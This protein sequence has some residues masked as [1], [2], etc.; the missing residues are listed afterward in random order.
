MTRYDGGHDED[1]WTVPAEWWGLAEPFRGLNDQPPPR[2]NRNALAELRMTVTRYRSTIDEVLAG[3]RREGLGNIAEAAERSV[4]L[5]AQASPLGA[6][7]IS[8][9]V[10]QEC[11]RTGSGTDAFRTVIADQFVDSWIQARGLAFAAETAVL[12][13]GLR[14]ERREFN[15]PGN[16]F[17]WCSALATVEPDGMGWFSDFFGDDFDFVGWR[18]RTHLAAAPETQYRAAAERLSAARVDPGTVWAR[19][20]TSY[21]LPERQDWLDEDLA[22]D[23]LVPRSG[24]VRMLVSAATTA[25]QFSRFGDISGTPWSYDRVRMY[26]ILTQIEPKLSVPTIVRKLEN[27][28]RSYRDNDARLFTALLA[29]I[30]SDDAYRA[31]LDHAH[32]GYGA[33]AL[34]KAS[35]RFPCR[36]ARL[37]PERMAETPAPV[38]RRLARSYATTP[39]S[40]HSPALLPRIRLRDSRAAL[41][42]ATVDELV[43]LLMSGPDGDAQVAAVTTTVDRASLA[44]FAWALFDAWCL[45]DSPARDR[46]VFHALGLLGDDGTVPRLMRVIHRW[47]VRSEQSYAVAG[48]GVLAT[49][50]SEPALRELR[51]LARHARSDELRSVAGARFREHADGLG[52]T[53]DALAHKLLPR[54]SLNSDGTMT[55]DFGPRQFVVGVD[56][57]LRPTVDGRRRRS[58]P[59][60]TDG[61]EPQLVATA[62][63]TFR[64]FTR[65]LKSIAGEHIRRLESALIHGTRWTVAEHR[66]VFLEHPVL[67]QATQRLVWAA[68][69]ENGRATAAF[70]IDER[71]VYTDSSGEPVALADDIL[72]GVAH[73]FHLGTVL[74][75][76]QQLFADAG[77]SQPIRQLDRDIYVLTTAEATSRQL[78]RFAGR[79]VRGFRITAL[80]G[81]GWERPSDAGIYTH[82]DRRFPIGSVR[83]TFTLGIVSNAD[84]HWDERTVV[85]VELTGVETVFGD[86]DPITASELLRQLTEALT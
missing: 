31:L 11:R 25:T 4:A 57:R 3:A 74:L 75:A 53:P 30:P 33:E 39:T 9:I 10:E 15:T 52:I 27:S 67:W 64:H 84:F 7:T 48:I 56:E 21:L 58:L 23:G 72:I 60:P 24:P 26:S 80:T 42:E 68:F 28:S 38:V 86:F 62:R 81:Y 41:P 59:A 16:Y 82:L 78:A 5:G 14:M 1:V 34:I 70:R 44:G 22:V 18:V 19:L 29:R 85:D 40:W 35:A 49:I 79:S 43:T 8:V 12:R 71:R 17:R 2:L 6:A 63:R 55:L 47:S 77:L 50:G 61:D 13:R 76:W 69:D 73:P 36:A 32:R 37:L 65:D 45:M 20:A 83:L 46:W 66:E 51:N 54:T